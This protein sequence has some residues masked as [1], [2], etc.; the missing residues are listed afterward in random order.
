MNYRVC[1]T[2]LQDCLTIL[3]EININFPIIFGII[4]FFIMS[5]ALK[6]SRDQRWNRKSDNVFNLLFVLKI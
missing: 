1:F 2:F 5:K 6:L 3:S 4:F